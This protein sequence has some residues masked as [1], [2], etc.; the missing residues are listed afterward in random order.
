[1]IYIHLQAH[2]DRE[3]VLSRSSGRLWTAQN[4]QVSDLV[5]PADPS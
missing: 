2:L 1:M 3:A 5:T 4:M